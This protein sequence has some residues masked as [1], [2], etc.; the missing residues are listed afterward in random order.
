MNTALDVSEAPWKS[1]AWGSFAEFA[2]ALTDK[3]T[4]EADSIISVGTTTR[5]VVNSADDISEG[6]IEYYLVGDTMR[7]AVMNYVRN[8]DRTIQV[9]DNGWIRFNFSLDLDVDMQIGEVGLFEVDGPSW[10]IIHLPEGSKTVERM[11]AD[12]TLKWV[13]VCVRPGKVAELCGIDMA[14]LPYP[15]GSLSGAP[16]DFRIYRSFELTHRLA[17]LTADI[18]NTRLEDRIRVN[19]VV[20]KATE[21]VLL[22]LNHVIHLPDPEAFPLS[23]EPRDIEKVLEARRI[24]I[25]NLAYVPSVKDLSRA[26]G[27]NR[28]KLYY[29]FRTQFGMTI[30]E[31]VKTQR[32]AEG[33]RLLTETNLSIADV[34]SQVGFQYQCNF[35]TSMK[36]KYGLTPSQ[37][38]NRNLI[39]LN[40]KVSPGR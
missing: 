14:N 32:L 10:R 4:H 37:L 20:N 39:E 2:T 12:T 35:S 16:D 28:N 38:R 7:I 26:M 22:A 34:S 23:L 40:E 30:S 17:R 15:L 3:E 31:F 33:Y 9:F 19:F 5:Y 13:T 25:E 1:F 36:A 24:I 6:S 8:C 27:I 21:L 18:L 29:G 11:K